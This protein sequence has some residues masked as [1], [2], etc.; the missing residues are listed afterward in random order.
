MVEKKFI[1]EF[2]AINNNEKLIEFNYLGQK[3]R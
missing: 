3:W 1:S 2:W